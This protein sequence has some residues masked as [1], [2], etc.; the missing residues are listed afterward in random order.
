MMSGKIK[1]NG[2]YGAKV[3]GRIVFTYERAIEIYK[4]F[5]ESAYAGNDLS[6]GGFLV[7]SEV[8]DDL[9]KIGFDR[10]EIEQIEFDYLQS[11][12]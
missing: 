3:G 6:Y 8:E 2:T 1:L 9:V 4:L 12:A 11:I 10:E 5:L 7:L